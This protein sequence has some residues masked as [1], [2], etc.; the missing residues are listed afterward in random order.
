[1][2]KRKLTELQLEECKRVFAISDRDGSGT[3]N[4][5]ELRTVL[6]VRLQGW[7]YKALFL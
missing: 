6:Q 5:T 1:M 7:L 4:T 3:I 2:E